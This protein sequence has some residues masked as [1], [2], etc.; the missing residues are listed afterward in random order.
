MTGRCASED[1]GT[2]SI[3]NRIRN[4]NDRPLTEFAKSKPEAPQ[5][6]Q[7]LYDRGLGCWTMLEGL[8]INHY[9]TRPGWREG[10]PPG[11]GTVGAGVRELLGSVI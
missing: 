6:D 9:S 10:E 3:D 8:G 7:A 1:E 5:P 2:T 11:M 4:V